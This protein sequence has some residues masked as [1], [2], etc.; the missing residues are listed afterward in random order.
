MQ[1]RTPVDLRRSFQQVS[2]S[3]ARLLRQV[4]FWVTHAGAKLRQILLGIASVDQVTCFGSGQSWL[5]L[6]TGFG[7]GCTDCG[8][9]HDL[10]SNPSWW[11]LVTT[12]PFTQIFSEQNFFY[13]YIITFYYQHYT[14]CMVK[15][16]CVPLVS[17]SRNRWLWVCTNKSQQFLI[18]WRLPTLVWCIAGTY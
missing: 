14:M 3:T 15:P 9:N 13:V 11:N 4:A 16:E 5:G 1:Q 8:W 17:G 10:A 6:R 2:E 7:C 12:R 18:W